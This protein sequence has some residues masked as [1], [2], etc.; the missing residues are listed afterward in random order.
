MGGDGQRR[1]RDPR[2]VTKAERDPKHKM[3]LVFRAYLGQASRWAINGL[4]ERRSDYQI[5]CGPAMGAFNAW[6]KGSFLEA[7]AQRHVVAVA[8]NLLEGAC[9]VTRA[10]Q[11]RSAG[12]AVP[13]AAFAYRPRPIGD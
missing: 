6:T 2:E 12:A 8:R 3:A 5:W 1:G 7:P 4:T 13:A 11:L 10:G 9:V